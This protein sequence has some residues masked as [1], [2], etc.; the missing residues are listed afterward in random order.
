MEQLVDQVVEAAP[1]PLSA[2]EVNR[3]R[4]MLSNSEFMLRMSQ[5]EMAAKVAKGIAPSDWMLRDEE[6]FRA[7]VDNAKRALGLM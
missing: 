2:Y 7:D 6:R 4:S 5:S 3:L 1:A